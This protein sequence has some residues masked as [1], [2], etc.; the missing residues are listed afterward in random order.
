MGQPELV[1]AERRRPVCVDCGEAFPPV[2][3]RDAAL[4]APER[5]S[6]CRERRRLERNAANRVTLPRPGA[7]KPAAPTGGIG[8]GR[9]ALARC[10]DCGREIRVPFEPDPS[11]AIYCRGCLSALAGR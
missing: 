3:R 5:C 10:A 6:S 8:G 7:A 1:E 11:R 9:L 4:P 2:A